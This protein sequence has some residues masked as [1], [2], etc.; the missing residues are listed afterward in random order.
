MDYGTEQTDYCAAQQERS[1]GLRAK[2]VLDVRVC[3]DIAG[4]IVERSGL[5]DSTNSRPVDGM[6]ILRHAH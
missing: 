3:A 6:L 4:A 5:R 2:P 1:S